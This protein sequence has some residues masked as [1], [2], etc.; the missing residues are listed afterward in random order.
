MY[1]IRDSLIEQEIKK[2][3]SEKKFSIILLVVVV[4]FFLVALLNTYVFGTVIV[5]GPSM[6]NTLYTGD[7]L[8]VNK[9]KSPD[10]G[11][12]IVI[13]GENSS[14]WIIKRVIGLPGD[15]VKI[16]EGYVYL[17]KANSTQEILLQEDY[18]KEQGK[19]YCPANPSM[20]EIEL[21]KQERVFE[22]GEN[23]I[24]YLGDNRMNS[25]D[26]RK[27]TYLCCNFNQIV[28]VVEDWALQARGIIK[29]FNFLSFN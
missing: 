6:E 22:V 8:K 16:R 14:A 25:S 7:V 10:R 12:I 20:G 23:E 9:L 13:A 24:F 21:A 2:S 3:K 19:T 4:V 29:F 17:I 27:E 11:D 28:G 15:T 5:Y 26:S 1:K 18:V